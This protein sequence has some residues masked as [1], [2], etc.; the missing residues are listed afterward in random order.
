[1]K[2]DGLSWAQMSEELRLIF[3]VE[4][5]KDQLKALVR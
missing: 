3:K 2:T 4:L 5:D 1:M